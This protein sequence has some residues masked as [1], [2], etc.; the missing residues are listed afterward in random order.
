MWLPKVDGETI[1]PA[2]TPS[3]SSFF[4]TTRSRFSIKYTRRSKTCGPIGTAVESLLNSRCSKLT[5]QFAK[6]M[7]TREP[8]HLCRPLLGA[9][10]PA[11]DLGRIF[12]KN[13]TERQARWKVF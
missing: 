10:G 9:Q 2:Q 7:L 4:P 8:P 3:S 12:N 11:G 13:P 6:E 1:R 5:V